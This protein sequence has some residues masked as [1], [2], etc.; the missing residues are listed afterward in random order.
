MTLLH[1]E[2]AKVEIFEKSNV[3]DLQDAI[4]DFIR[5]KTLMDIKYQCMVY[6]LTGS[7]Y[8]S[9]VVIYKDDCITIE[10]LMKQMKEDQ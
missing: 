1:C 4:N 8:Y 2:D 6:N 10:E 7:C 5:G 3:C 9:A